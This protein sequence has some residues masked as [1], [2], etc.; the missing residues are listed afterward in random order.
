[1]RCRGSSEAIRQLASKVWA[2]QDPLHSSNDGPSMAVSRASF[3]RDSARAGRGGIVGVIRQESVKH[4]GIFYWSHHRVDEDADMWPWPDWEV[5]RPRH[6]TRGD[7]RIRSRH[8]AP[9][10]SITPRP[11]EHDAARWQRKRQ[12]GIVH[13]KKKGRRSMIQTEQNTFGSRHLTRGIVSRKLPTIK[14]G[15]PRSA[16]HS[17]KW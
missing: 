12:P 13:P 1:M 9:S 8:A 14:V 5:T 7:T 17:A 4:E 6:V 2:G 10:T 3:C 11:T 15:L 16:R